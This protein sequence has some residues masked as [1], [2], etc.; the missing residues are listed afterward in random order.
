MNFFEILQSRYYIFKVQAKNCG[1][2]STGVSSQI[3]VASASVLAKILQAPMKRSVYAMECI[4][5][6]PNDVSKICN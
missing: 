1:R 6:R 4:E 2:F 3:T 5:S